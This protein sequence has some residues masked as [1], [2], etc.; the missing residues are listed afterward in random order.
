VPYKYSRRL[1]EW[2]VRRLE[3]MEVTERVEIFIKDRGVAPPVLGFGELGP[4][5]LESA[6]M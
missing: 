6:Q 3:G 4:I 1:R 2:R 5:G